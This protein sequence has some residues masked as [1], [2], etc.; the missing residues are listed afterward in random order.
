MKHKSICVLCFLGWTTTVF[1]QSNY[2][3]IKVSDYLQ[4][5]QYEEAIAYLLPF[6]EPDSAHP[7]ILNSIGYALFMNEQAKKAS[8]YFQRALRLDSGNTMSLYY[9]SA[10][11]S[12]DS[13][14]K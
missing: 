2:D 7:A 4:N 9:L 1:A 3:K 10:I 12:I 13:P 14:A 8:L 11:C 5:Q 6:A